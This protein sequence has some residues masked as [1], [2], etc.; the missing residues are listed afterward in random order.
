MYIGPPIL[1]TITPV[2]YVIAG[3]SFTLNCTATNDP[4][5]PNELRFRWF[6]ESTR[7]INDI[8]QW[9]ITELS[10]RNTLTVTSQVVITHL[11]M[12]QHNGKYRCFVDNFKTRAAIRQTTTVIVE[13]E[14]AASYR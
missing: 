13:S 12:K 14:Y 11:T 10:M 5:S 2:Y 9:N 8:S 6:K 4:Q 3:D 1:H 7:I